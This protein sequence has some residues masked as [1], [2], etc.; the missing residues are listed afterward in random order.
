MSHFLSVG[1]R[2]ECKRHDTTQAMYITHTTFYSA[3]RND[4]K[5]IKCNKQHNMHTEHFYG[6][7]DILLIILE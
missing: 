1:L 2:S 6:N 7:S 3:C 4:A 5:H